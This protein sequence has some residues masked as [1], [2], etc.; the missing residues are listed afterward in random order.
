MKKFLKDIISKVICLNYETEAIISELDLSKSSRRNF[1][2]ELFNDY[3]LKPFEEKD[4]ADVLAFC[5][6]SDAREVIK[7]KHFVELKYNGILFFKD[8][9]LIGYLWWHDIQLRGYRFELE[10]L[11]IKLKRENEIYGEYYYIKP[12]Y[13]GQGIALYLLSEIHSKWRRD[14]YTKL[15]G[16]VFKDN[17]S[18][19]WVNRILG[20]EEIKRIKAYSIIINKKKREFFFYGTHPK[21]LFLFFSRNMNRF[22]KRIVLKKL[23]NLRSLLFY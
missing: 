2:K 3:K 5:E 12:E 16:F 19:R 13:R 21:D 7:V 22:F 10:K 18:A 11:P 4:L 1:K 15:Y 8:T 6:K 14:G 23:I 20:F 17:I 9:A